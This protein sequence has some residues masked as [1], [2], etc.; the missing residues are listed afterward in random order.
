MTVLDKAAATNDLAVSAKGL[1]H[2]FGRNWA[3]RSLDLAVPKGSVF[4]FLGLNGAGKST[5]IRMLMGLLGAHEGECRVLGL[6][7]DANEVELK[8]RVGYVPDAPSFYDW[9]TAE[10]M[11]GLVAHYRADQWDGERAAQLLNNFAVPVN[12]KLK[13]M[14]KGQR[15]K[16][17]L[18][19][20]LAFNPELLMLDEPTSG[21]DPVARREFLEGV[22]GEFQDEG[23]TVFVSS[24]LV[25]EIQGLVDMVGILHEGQLIRCVSM[26]ALR[27]KARRVRLAFEDQAPAKIECNGLLRSINSGRESILTFD[28]FD[29]SRTPEQLKQYSPRILSVEPMSLEDLFVEVVGAASAQKI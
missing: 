13:T 8:R 10:Q 1:G 25:N 6:S 9:M 16:V 24:H 28:E 3:V 21:L 26:D 29:E 7:P 5:T 17:A 23:R 2:R 18:T 14:S 4:G 15:S 19:M 20:A 27:A 22:L 11:L 12:Q